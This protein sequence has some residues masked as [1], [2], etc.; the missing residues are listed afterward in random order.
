MQSKR[1]DP[2]EQQSERAH[3]ILEAQREAHDTPGADPSEPGALIN[4]TGD[5]GGA[6]S[7]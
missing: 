2:A 5:D 4:N 6:A 1:R 7:G 3:E